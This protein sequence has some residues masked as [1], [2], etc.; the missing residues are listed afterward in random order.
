[1]IY[2]GGGLLFIFLLYMAIEAKRNRVIEETIVFKTLPKAFDG[3]RLF[4]I[5]DIHRRVIPES[6]LQKIEKETDMIIIGGDL[7]E[8][9]VPLKRIEKN[10]QS[11][12]KVAPC[13][14]IWGNNDEEVGID[15]LRK[16]FEAHGI[17]ELSNNKKFI[18]KMDGELIIASVDDVEQDIPL[19][20]YDIPKDKFS[21]LICHFPEVSEML[22]PDHPYSLILSGHTHGGQIRIFGWGIAQKGQWIERA[23]CKQLISN[24]Y[25]TTGLPLRLGAPCETHLLTLKSE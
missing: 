6:L 16:I 8:K 17:M 18:Q 23:S 20:L 10:L 21:I 12:S 13:L 11:L 2:V 15:N 19:T 3:Y 7:C 9:G 5:S 24:G 1:M 25:G 14:F 22:K 4:F